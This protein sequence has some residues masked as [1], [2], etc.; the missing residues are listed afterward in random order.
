VG[1]GENVMIVLDVER[2][3]KAAFQF[4]AWVQSLLSG[5]IN[6]ALLIP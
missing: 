2:F 4:C 5:T 1:E 6:R 3:S